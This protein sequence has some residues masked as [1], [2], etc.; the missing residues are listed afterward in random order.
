M[1]NTGA[2]KATNRMKVALQIMPCLP[3]ECNYSDVS[4]LN[5]QSCLSLF[6]LN[7]KVTTPNLSLFVIA[8]WEVNSNT[9]GRRIMFLI[10]VKG[11]N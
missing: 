1:W 11:T 3:W 5:Q 6:S 10:T 2:S 4:S 8:S 9:T 7:E